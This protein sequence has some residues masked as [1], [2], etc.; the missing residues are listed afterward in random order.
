MAKSAQDRRV[1]TPST[2]GA[3][4]DRRPGHSSHR[5]VCGVDRLDHPGT[6]GR[7]ARWARSTPRRHRRRADLPGR[8][9]S[10]AGLQRRAPLAAGRVLPGRASVPP[11]AVPARLQP[12]AARQ[13]RADGGCPALAGRPYPATAE[14]LRLL[15]GTPVVCGR[16]RRTATHSGL[17][18]WAGYGHDTSHHC[19]YW[20]RRLLLLSTPDG[21]VTGFGLANPKLVGE[22]EAV[23]AMLGGVPANRPAPGTLL[24]GDKGFAGRAFQTALAGLELGILVPLAPTNPTRGLSELAA[25]ADRGDHLDPQAPARPGP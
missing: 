8:G 11:A 23:V 4:R 1:Y 14:L 16:S 6:T 5:T 15:D 10:P 2:S 3:V 18:G 12:S 9:P 17:A 22:R 7:A 20:G 25:T 24:V 21:T 19:F 13:R